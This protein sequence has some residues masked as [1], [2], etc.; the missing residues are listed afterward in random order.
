MHDIGNV[1]KYNRGKRV[2]GGGYWGVTSEASRDIA[3]WVDFA[4]NLGFERVILVGHSAGWAS[5]AR[6][7]ADTRD[8]RVAGLVMASGGVRPPDPGIGDPAWVAQAKKL[9]DAGAGEDLMRIPNRSYPSFTSAA[10]ELD[11]INK[12]P[13]YQDFFG[14]KIQDPAI[15]RVGCP[16]LAFFG[17]GYDMGVATL[18]RRSRRGRDGAGPVRCGIPS[19]HRSLLRDRWRGV[20]RSPRPSVQSTACRS[21]PYD[22]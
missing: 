19:R 11:I 16:L 8:K 13:A 22:L 2:R 12:P 9:V 21:A 20:E 3:A 7:Q 10:T 14:T 6:Y 4:Q 15:M 17:T 1:L 5:V 18:E